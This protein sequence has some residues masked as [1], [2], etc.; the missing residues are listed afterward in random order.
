MNKI[1]IKNDNKINKL[2]YVYIISI[3]PL[4]LY[5]LYKNGILLYQNDLISFI[6]IFKILIFI[7]IP[8]ITI[9]ILNYIKDKKIHIELNNLSW[10]FISIFMPVNTNILIYSCLIILFIFLDIRLL[11]SKVDLS[12]VFKIILILILYL[13]GNYSYLNIAEETISYNFNTLD[14][15]FGRSVGGIA[16]T[17]LII[18]MLSYVLLYTNTF[19]K[20]NITIVT[21]STYS[22]LT[23][24]LSFITNI[25][26][27]NIGGIFIGVM[28]LGSTLKYTPATIKSQIIYSFS[29]G[30]LIVLFNFINYYESLFISL[31]ILQS[32]IYIKGKIRGRKYEKNNN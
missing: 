29:L 7:G 10:I 9:L 2:V 6:E 24:V 27:T 28:L 16:S 1:Y 22:A 32:L 12:L 31:L 3:L 18:A 19:Y 25:D 17:S 11:K 30:I 20:K 13:L 23:L 5:G 8:T 4:I 26:F 21:I 15:L 14:I